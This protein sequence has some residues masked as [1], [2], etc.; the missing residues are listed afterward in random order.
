MVDEDETELRCAHELEPV[1]RLDD[2]VVTRT[3]AFFRAAGDP[4]RLRLLHHLSVHGPCCVSEVS[5]F[6]GEGMST[7]SQRLKVLRSERLVTR[8]RD[9]KHIYYALADDHVEQIVGMA[10]AHAEEHP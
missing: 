6:F 2:D 5:A 8:R 3:A 4:A 10:L 1:P 7:I 9:G